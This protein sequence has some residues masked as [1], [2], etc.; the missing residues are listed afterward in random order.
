MK[1]SAEFHDC[2]LCKTPDPHISVERPRLPVFQNVVHPTYEQARDAPSAPFAL[3]TCP[4]CG[5]SYNAV[6]DA[7][8]VT[9]DTDYDNHVESTAFRRY[10][11]DLAQMMITRFDLS[12]GTVY[13][14][15]CG[16]GEFLRSLCALAPGIRG[17]GIDP[18]CTPCVDGNF[19]L[20][21]ATFETSDINGDARLVILRHVLEH[22]QQPAVFLAGLRAAMP[23]APLYV[24][25]PD[26]TWIL[27]HTA[28][29]DFC[30]EHC[31]YFTPDTLAS[32]MRG[33]GFDVLGQDVAF[34]GQYQWIIGAPAANPGPIGRNAIVARAAVDAY[35]AR[36]TMAVGSL[37]DLAD[38]D[39]GLAV[40]GMATKGVLLAIL[41][42]GD[43]VIGG[44]DMNKAKQ[45]FYAAGSGVRIN[46]LEWLRDLQP[47]TRVVVMNPNYLA[48]IQQSVTSIRGDLQ[49][50]SV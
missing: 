15:G 3:G 24:E 41:L 43:R 14:V 19:E 4:A 30:Y 18:S 36:E 2:R 20:R 37:R 28:F 16:K 32:A 34:G 40:W 33:A 29:W 8:L 49:V 48:E 38:R 23:N 42:G 12:H 6:F 9:Y 46:S 35:L 47:G 45:G 10:Y 17:I 26:L 13:D 11:H 25:V 44:I 21:R 1:Q 39:G 7:G 27:H 50:M 31:N 22:I 5:F